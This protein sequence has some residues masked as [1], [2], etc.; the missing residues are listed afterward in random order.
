MVEFGS[1]LM[2]RGAGYLAACFECAAMGVQ[3][4]EG[5]QQRGVDVDQAA[6]IV[7]HELG[8]EDAHEAGQ[9]HQGWPVG[10]DA[11][12]QGG[13]ECVSR[14]VG[15][16]IDHLAGQSGL[17]RQSQPGGIA[18]VADDRGDAGVQALRPLLLLGRLHQGLQIAAGPRDQDNDVAQG[19][20][21]GQPDLYI[22]A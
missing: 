6:L 21:H 18:A 22:L 10:V 3:A 4:G 17:A 15:G 7:P 5:G 9:Q 11:G 2:H 16:V 1:D 12:H 20:A 14:R 13:V 8:R 19:H